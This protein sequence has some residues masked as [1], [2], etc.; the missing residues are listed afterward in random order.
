MLNSYVGRD[1]QIAMIVPEPLLVLVK[2]HALV[3]FSYAATRSA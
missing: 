1:F 2:S 3:S